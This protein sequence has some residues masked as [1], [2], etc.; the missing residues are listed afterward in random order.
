MVFNPM[1]PLYAIITIRRIRF[2]GVSVTH[3]HT[4]TSEKNRAISCDF[5]L[6]FLFSHIAIINMAKNC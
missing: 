4:R 6:I 5:Y 2:D 3:L 1:Q